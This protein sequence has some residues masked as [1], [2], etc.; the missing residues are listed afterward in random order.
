MPAKGEQEPQR[1]REDISGTK[2]RSR[3]KDTSPRRP[4]IR[5]TSPVRPPIDPEVVAKA[6]GAERVP[7]EEVPALLRRLGIS[8]R[9]WSITGRSPDGVGKEGKKS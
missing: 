8:G 6:L 1:S 9:E 4:L 3:I 5:D 7:S 2:T